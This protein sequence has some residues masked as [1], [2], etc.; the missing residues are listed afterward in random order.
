MCQLILELGA[1][2][3]V[4]RHLLLLSGKGLVGELHGLQHMTV[5]SRY[6]GRVLTSLSKA[7]YH[8]ILLS[9]QCG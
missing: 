3:Y 8:F 4:G 2:S 5:V 7:S 1:P 9:G 6:R